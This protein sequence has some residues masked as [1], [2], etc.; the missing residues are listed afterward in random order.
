[1]G[2]FLRQFSPV[3]RDT[4]ADIFKFCNALNFTYTFQ[5]KELLEA[6]QRGDPR[7]ACKSGQGPGKTTIAAVIGLWRTWRRYNAMTVVTAPTYRQCHEV[8]LAECRR[9]M[10]KADPMIQK[11]FKITKTKVT[12]GDEPDWGIKL[13][14]ATKEENAQGYHDPNMTVIV[15]E[16]SGVKRDIITQFKGTLSNPNSLLLMI[17][18]PNTRDCSFF[19]CFNS[20]RDKWETMTFNAEETPESA[21]FSYQ[22]NRDLEEEFGRDSDVYRIRVLGEFPHSDPNCVVSSDDLEKVC[23]KKLIVPCSRIE[24]GGVVGAGYAKQFGMDFARFGGDEN[25]YYRRSGNAIVEGMRY[26]HTDPSDVVDKVFRSQ[27][28]AAW[29]DKDCHY[30]VDAGGMG[31]GVMHRFYD[32]GK[33]V[34]E[35][36]NGGKA[37]KKDYENKITEAWFHLA[38]MVRKGICCLPK[39]NILMQQLCSRQYYTTRKGKLVLETKDEYMKRGH[40][41]P[42]RADAAVMTFYDH[43]EV[44]GNI[45]TRDRSRHNVGTALRAA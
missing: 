14:T 23:L 20:Q 8:W 36:H 24:R 37:H 32:A 34:L 41:S 31:Q 13:V 3:Y 7:I 16:A 10:A 30:V 43:V 21:W 17:G 27:S 19:D 26:S 6:V 18:N 9:V 12:L 22:R 25:V 15:E 28:E 5:Q 33:N 38:Q 4:S 2:R 39:D 1:M 44:T 40:E 42:D 45:T 29:K 11:F 35:F